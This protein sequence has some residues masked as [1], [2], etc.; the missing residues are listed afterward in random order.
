[1]AEQTRRFVEVGDIIGL[2]F[3]CKNPECGVTLII[4]MLEDVNRNQALK[5]CPNCGKQWAEIENAT[6]E[7]KFKELVNTL[8][9]IGRAP[10]GCRFTLEI[11][12]ES[13]EAPPS[14]KR[15]L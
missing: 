7:A 1:M 15:D 10:I 11:K 2:R 9:A 4:P 13:Q 6:Y 3:D 14:S 12:S 5:K 8:R